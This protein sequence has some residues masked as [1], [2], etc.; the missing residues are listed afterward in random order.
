VGL[1]ER[2]LVAGIL[3]S[4]GK[5]AERGTKRDGIYDATGE[6]MASHRGC[7]VDEGKGEEEGGKE[8]SPGNSGGA[9]IIALLPSATTH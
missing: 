7:R 9:F 8:W 6:R 1:R 5:I 2:G 3:E 4:R